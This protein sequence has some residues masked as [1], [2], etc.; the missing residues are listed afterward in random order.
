MTFKADIYSHSCMTFP[1]KLKVGTS[2]LWAC[3]FH[4][5]IW[6]IFSIEFV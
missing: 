5:G 4:A 6:K 2:R 3:E 1:L